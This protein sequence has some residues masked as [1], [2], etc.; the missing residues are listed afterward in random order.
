MQK[1][2]D[3]M[4][5]EKDALQEQINLQNAEIEAE[6]LAKRQELE[7]AESNS[8]REANLK[9]YKKDALGRME[10]FYKKDISCW[11]FWL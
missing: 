3:E 9:L 6:R 4:Q 11:S 8:I 7:V 1:E 2:R 10:D 5:R